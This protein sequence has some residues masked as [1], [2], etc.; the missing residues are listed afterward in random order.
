MSESDEPVEPT[1]VSE[2]EVEVNRK[3]MA[4]GIAQ[5]E[6]GVR[7]GVRTILNSLRVSGPIIALRPELVPGVEFAKEL[8]E[9]T[10]S[11][12]QTKKKKEDKS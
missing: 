9:L 11:E 8:A 2:S 5:Y 4:F 7:D 1:A 12:F 10:L 6:E 3:L